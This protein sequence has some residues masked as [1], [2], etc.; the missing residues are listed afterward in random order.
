MLRFDAGT[1]ID[2]ADDDHVGVETRNYW[3]ND[4]I[5]IMKLIW[6]TGKVNPETVRISAR[7]QTPSTAAALAA[8]DRNLLNHEPEVE[9][10]SGTSYCC[11]HVVQ[12]LRPKRLD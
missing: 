7:N 3:E 9:Q 11:G 8:M 1:E 10:G 6:C 2:T 12:A 5:E 4:E